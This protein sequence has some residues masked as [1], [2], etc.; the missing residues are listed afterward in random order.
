VTINTGGGMLTRLR[1]FFALP[2]LDQRSEKAR[3]AGL[4]RI[5]LSVFIVVAIVQALGFVLGPARSVFN[6]VVVFVLL[7]I[8][9]GAFFVARAG[10]VRAVSIGFVLLMWGAVVWRTLQTGGV[11]GSPLVG[12]IVLV[13]MAGLLLGA[14]A[15]VISA[16]A[17]AIF[18][19][20]FLILESRGVLSYTPFRN[21]VFESASTVAVFAAVA[22]LVYLYQRGF[23]RMVERAKESEEAL[24]DTNRAYEVRIR[25]LE[26]LIAQLKG[27]AEVSRAAVSVHDLDALLAEVTQL[28]DKLFD[29]YHLGIFLLSDDGKWAEL[30][31]SNSEGGQRMLARK[32]KLEVGQQGIVGYVTSTGEPRIALDVGD[33]PVHFQNPDLPQTRSEMALPLK[34]GD[35]IIGALDVQSKQEAAYD[36]D[37]IMAFHMM[38]DHLAMTIENARL[39]G[40]TQQAVQALSTRATQILAT[41]TQQASG[42][43]EQSAAISQATTTVDEIRTIAEQLVSRSQSVAD[44]AQRSVE[45]SRAGQEMVRETIAG[46]SQ[47]KA[48]VD[49]IEENILALSER[50]QQIGEIIDTVE[51]IASQSNMLA[52]N[53]AVEAARAGEQGKGFA[54][55]AEE[56]RDLAERSRQATVQIKGI[57]SDIQRATNATGMA[58][59]EGKK[60]VDAGVKLVAQMGDAI[61]QLAQTI[62]ASAQ[63]AVQMVAG[64]QQQTS[65]MEQIAVAMQNINQVTVQNLSS[66]RQAEKSAQEL[67]EVAQ[68][69][70]DIVEQYRV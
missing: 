56:V 49:V 51:S 38:A 61:D 54:V 28:I 58:T 41:T 30:W 46:M 13:L 20:V 50:T 4:L 34:V 7:A 32:H 47:I 52:L 39:L 48:R 27:V 55:V 37:D 40:A 25:H 1:Q 64:G 16:S 24:S 6:I 53:A 57:L 21:L 31:A 33:D 17:S 65:G 68:G 15:A 29:F 44:T 11:G 8:L 42:A 14:R 66:T 10:Y 12:H 69:L 19:V 26:H 2:E 70:T 62:D 45:V 22:V 60:G 59:E 18:G 43:T 63:S 5:I 3:V 36:Q 67:N 23:Q 35:R 9:I